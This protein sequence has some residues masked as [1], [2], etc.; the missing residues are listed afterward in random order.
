MTREAPQFGFIAGEVGPRFY[1]RS[2]LVKFGFGAKLLQN[3][4]VDERGGA[5]NRRGWEMSGIVD[6]TNDYSTQFTQSLARFRH[7]DGDLL[8]VHD[9]SE[10]VMFARDGGF[11]LEAAK[12]ITAITQSTQTTVTVTSQ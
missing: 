10:D 11:V 12:S 9:P 2:D 8:A 3:W 1:G 7:A 4:I 5:K 6:Y